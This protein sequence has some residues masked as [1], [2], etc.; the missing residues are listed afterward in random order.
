MGYFVNRQLTNPK[1]TY[2]VNKTRLALTKREN[3]MKIKPVLINLT[4]LVMLAMLG[5]V[6]NPK[7]NA[8]DVTLLKFFVFCLIFGIPL[9]L[10]ENRHRIGHVMQR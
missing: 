5:V 2:C 7:L 4:M 1:T 10:F 3:M 9:F 8:Y 6:I